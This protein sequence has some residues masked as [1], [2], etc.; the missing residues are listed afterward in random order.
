VEYCLSLSSLSE[1]FWMSVYLCWKTEGND[2]VFTDNK[3]DELILEA[4]VQ[5]RKWLDDGL[6][7]ENIAFIIYKETLLIIDGGHPLN[8]ACNLGSTRLVIAHIGKNK[9]DTHR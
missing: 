3:K 2:Y 1:K 9:Q 5:Y 4:G 7:I 8:N 6:S